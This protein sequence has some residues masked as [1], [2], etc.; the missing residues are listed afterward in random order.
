ML[1]GRLVMVGEG[2]KSS[3]RSSVGIED[4]KDCVM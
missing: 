1:E 3:N 2:N 4:G